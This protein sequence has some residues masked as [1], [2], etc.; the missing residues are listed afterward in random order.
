MGMVG[1]AVCLLTGLGSCGSLYV[2]SYNSRM[3]RRMSHQTHYRE[4]CTL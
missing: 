3:S 4:T 2:P 1:Q